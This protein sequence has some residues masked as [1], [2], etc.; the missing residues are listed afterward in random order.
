M[1]AGIAAGSHFH[2]T[3]TTQADRKQ[4]A[5]A[6]DFEAKLLQ[7]Q[8]TAEARRN[9]LEKH[10]KALTLWRSLNNR[11]AEAETLG[12]IGTIHGQLG[13]RQK[14]IEAFQQQLAIW[15]RMP[16][17]QKEAAESFTNLAIVYGAQG[18]QQNAVDSFLHAVSL[19]RQAGDRLGLASTLDQFGLFYLRAGELQKAS[20]YCGQALTI[21][22]E[23]PVA[24]FDF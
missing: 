2:Q 12:H 20:D 14:A 13:D 19:R 8:G 10:E 15:E 22:R 6:S 1:I 21:F 17:R 3:Q 18:Q 5:E 4:V 24:S 9:A 16:D 7:A 23:L 11:R